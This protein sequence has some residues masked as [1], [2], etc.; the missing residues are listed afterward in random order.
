MSQQATGHKHAHQT[1]SIAK[2]H[3]T[4]NDHYTPQTQILWNS[5]IRRDLD[6]TLRVESIALHYSFAS[7]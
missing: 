5:A 6:K 3:C 4:F 7:T 1:H 2:Q